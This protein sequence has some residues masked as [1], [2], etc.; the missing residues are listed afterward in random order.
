MQ[1]HKIKQ[2]GIT[3]YPITFIKEHEHHGNMNLCIKT[4]TRKHHPHGATSARPPVVAREQLQTEKKT[5]R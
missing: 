5:P 2:H 3:K 4:L 1:L